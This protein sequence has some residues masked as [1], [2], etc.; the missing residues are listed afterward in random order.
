LAHIE[1][2]KLVITHLEEEQEE[3]SRIDD[4]NEKQK[5]L[6]AIENQLKAAV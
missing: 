4:N 1:C 2:I 6:N 3:K 5:I